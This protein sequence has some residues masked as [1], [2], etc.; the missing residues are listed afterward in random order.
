MEFLDW[1]VDVSP[2]FIHFITNALAE[3]YF[4]SVIPLPDHACCHRSFISNDDKQR[5]LARVQ[6]H[7][8]DKL[9]N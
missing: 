4:E 3:T 5:F 7:Y 6:D 2:A 1:A 8:M 9:I